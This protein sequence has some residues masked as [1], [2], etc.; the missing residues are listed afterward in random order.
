MTLASDQK[1][2]P[3]NPSPIS[4]RL[5]D[6]KEE[7]FSE[8]ETRVLESVK[9]AA[10]VSHPILINTLPAL[11]LNLAEALTPDYPR[12]AAGVATPSVATEHG[13]ER[14][15][16]TNYEAQSV[17]AEYQ[18]LRATII[19]VLR[20]NQVPI[21]EK[22]ML[23]I[24][25]SIDAAIRESATAFTLAHSAFR[26]QMMATVVHDIRN[27]LASASYAVQ[28][29]RR[30]KDPDLIQR[31][32][33]KILENLNR[34][35]AM[36]KDILDKTLFE[37]GARLT[38]EPS[39]FD[40]LE[41][42]REVCRDSSSTLGERVVVVGGSCQGWWDRDY[43]RRA[44][45][46]MIGNALK[47][48][49]SDSQIRIVVAD[50]HGRLQLSV[51]NEGDPIP[52]DQMEAIFQ[53]FRRAKAAKQGDGKGWGIGLPFVRNVTECHGGSLDVDSSLERGTTFTMDI[54]V[55]CRPFLHAPVL[56]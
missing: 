27:P 1:E 25:A 4:Q 55:D 47:Y 8:W 21:S 39:H 40:V 50:Y 15:R 41:L 49:H 3:E 37:H 29:I 11:Y 36:L 18:L 48:G 31:Q 42:A 19:D 32:A 17:I 52:A 16:L 6:L 2:G 51:H 10:T 23:I 54:P 35:E 24:T 56:G 33:D 38:L 45:E 20:E 44:L 53:V 5:L 14:A 43:L 13:G 7:V 12:T 46:N 26:E 22:E 34:I 9:E 30:L 28:V